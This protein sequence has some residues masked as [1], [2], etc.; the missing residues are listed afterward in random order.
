MSG[1][2]AI[3]LS[4]AALAALAFSP[5]PQRPSSDD[6]VK[7]AFYNIKSGLGVQ[8]LRSHAA[9]FADGGNCTDSSKPMNAW[10][11]GVVQKTLTGALSDPSVVA[12]GLAEAWKA[13]CASP[14]HVRAALDWKTTASVQNGTSLVARYGL[15]DQRWQQL[16]TSA[17][18]N[19]SDTAWVL[20]ALVCTDP[21]CRDTLIAY[22]THWSATGPKQREIY[23][24]QARQ[25]V[26]WMRSTSGNERHVL[27]GDLNVWTAN[28]EVCRQTPNGAAAIAVL[29][30]AGYIDAWP[31][32]HGDAEG[33]TG[34]LN[35]VRC[36]TPEGYAWKRIDYAWS[37]SNYPPRD[38]SRFGVTPPGEPAPSDHYGIVVSYPKR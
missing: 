34:M 22:V 27:I 15:K 18:R 16:D 8:P 38:I 12:L 3:S 33:Y 25:T 32:I 37:P 14:E 20:R 30:G 6:T 31:R 13:T 17:N 7:L 4:C 5:L 24:L 23:E 21:G 29:S 36:G 2:F 19:P 35:R 26:D 10:G 11:T 28:G 9:T 1:K